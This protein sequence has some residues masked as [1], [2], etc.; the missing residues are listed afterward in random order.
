V[1]SLGRIFVGH[2]ERNRN[3][4]LRP[5]LA[6]KV[7]RKPTFWRMPA[8]PFP[9]DQGEEGAC[10]A[11][12]SQHELAAGPVQI[13]GASNDAAFALYREI[14]A[15]DRAMG[16]YFEDGATTQAAMKTLKN[17]GLISGYRWAFGI[18]DVVDSLCSVGPVCLGIEW[19][20]N[21]YS[22]RS[23][24]M[25]VASGP[26]VGG[27]FIT[28]VAYDV[29]PQLGPVVGWLNSWG[30]AYGI[31]DSRIG[32]VGGVGWIQVPTLQAILASD[33]EAVVPADF[34]SVTGVVTPVEPAPYFAQNRS[35][36]FHG[37]HRGYR[38]D[39]EF[40]T[41][42]EAIDTGYRPCRICRP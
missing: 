27:H 17:K 33:G 20:Y 3:Y 35:V 13:P 4:G 42:T 19:R 41:R 31:A 37:K 28:A 6:A 29:H 12:G 5:L 25:V 22:T 2:D 38:R 9:L 24:G 11:F 34:L 8:G 40:Q 7:E 39:V 30:R 15:T 26:V 32:V 21:M 14:Q 36:T 16:N 10:T 23:N 1:P 18:D